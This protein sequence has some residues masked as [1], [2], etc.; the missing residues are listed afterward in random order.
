MT[1]ARITRGYNRFGGKGRARGGI[2]V[3]DAVSMA[4]SNLAA[5][6]PRI[7]AELDVRIAALEDRFGSQ[8][9]G[10]GDEPIQALYDGALAVI[11]VSGGLPG[12]GL[13]EAAKALC[14][15]VMRS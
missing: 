2:S 12:S 13:D 15:L 1:K 4:D 6:L 9:A 10:R 3:A 8:A 11:E 14:E 7:M 5:L